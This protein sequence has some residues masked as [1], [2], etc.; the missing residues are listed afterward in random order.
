MKT[1]LWRG[2]FQYLHTISGR[3]TA[4]SFIKKKGKRVDAFFYTSE[5]D[6]ESK[7]AQ[8]VE[9]KLAKNEGNTEKRTKKQ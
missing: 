8:D 6:K 2:I 4:F 7:V 1:W 9:Y 3:L 5:I